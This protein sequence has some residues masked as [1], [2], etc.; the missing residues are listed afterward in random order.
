MHTLA[1]KT[2]RTVDG[3]AVPDGD[4]EAAFLVGSAGKQ[5]PMAD[6]VALGLA[7]GATAPAAA[8]DK[9]E[10][11]AEDKAVDRAVKSRARR[12]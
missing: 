5:I 10:P 3:R 2:W 12:G 4:P 11:L 7:P 1:A 9:A 8:E 6:A